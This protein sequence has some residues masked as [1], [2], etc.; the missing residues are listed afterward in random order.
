MSCRVQKNVNSFG[1]RKRLWIVR[2]SARCVNNYTYL[3]CGSIK[4]EPSVG[5]GAAGSAPGI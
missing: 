5:A 1:R 2:E 3:E 4:G